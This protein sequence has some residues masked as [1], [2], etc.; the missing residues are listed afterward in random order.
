VLLALV[1]VHTAAA[2]YHHFIKRDT[3]L[4]RMVVAIKT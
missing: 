4:K 1:V 2:L 3:V